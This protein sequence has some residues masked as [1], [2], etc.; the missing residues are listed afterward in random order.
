MAILDD[1]EPEIPTTD[2]WLIAA[3]DSGIPVYVP[4]WEDS[5]LGNIFAAHCIKGNVERSAVK[6]G[7]DYMVHL[8]DW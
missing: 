7:I 5:T 1:L 4:G 6:T 2:S 3:R 8:A